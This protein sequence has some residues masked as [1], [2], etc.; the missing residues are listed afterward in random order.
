M[1]DHHQKNS[2]KHFAI[3]NFNTYRSLSLSRIIPKTKEKCNDKNKKKRKNEE[4]KRWQRKNKNEE[5]G[6]RVKIS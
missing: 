6:T 1:K 4:L 2:F 5:R 3:H